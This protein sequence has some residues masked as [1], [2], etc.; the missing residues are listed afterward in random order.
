MFVQISLNIDEESID[1]LAKHFLSKRKAERQH[2]N[3]Q[4]SKKNEVLDKISDI[5]QTAQMMMQHQMSFNNNNN[6]D[7]NSNKSQVKEIWMVMFKN[8]C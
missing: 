4:K 8:H 7:N 2:K 3:K 5:A 6:N 1:E